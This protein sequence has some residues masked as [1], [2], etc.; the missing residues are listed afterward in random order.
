MR[1]IVAKIDKKIVDISV[2]L[3]DVLALGQI[4]VDTVG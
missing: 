3:G 2:G 4:S 1:T